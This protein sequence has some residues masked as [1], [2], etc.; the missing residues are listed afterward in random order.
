M[1]EVTVQID[2]REKQPFVFPATVT[3]WVKNK[4][5]ML[6]VRTE[7]VKLAAGDYRLKE[8]QD[9][10]VIERKG[11]VREL[12][13]NLLSGDQYRQGRAFRKL[14][15]SCSHPYLFLHTAAISLL[16]S[17]AFNPEPERLVQKLAWA[18]DKFGLHLVIV[19]L[20]SSVASRRLVG[21]VALN[22]MLGHLV[23]EL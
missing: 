21:K 11:S 23:P 1:K 18:V 12:A 9:K 19:P 20:A 22:L 5:Q 15:E 13:Q 2:T 7:R 4:P 10:G 17:S 6:R 8:A 16:G 3:V 14:R